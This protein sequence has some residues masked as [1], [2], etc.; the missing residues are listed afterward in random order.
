MNETH[1]KG[2]VW[3]EGYGAFTLGVS[4][5]PRTI[6]SIKRKLNIIASAASRMSLSHS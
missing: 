6:D 1:T 5:R 3:Q 4:Q 2:F